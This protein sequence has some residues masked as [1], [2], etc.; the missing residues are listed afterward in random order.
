MMLYFLF[1]SRPHTYSTHPQFFPLH[2]KS[3]LFIPAVHRF[4][5]EDHHFQLN[6]LNTSYWKDRKHSIGTPLKKLSQN[7][8]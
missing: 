8:Y 6:R 5:T 4:E 7:I 3:G 1:A 2:S